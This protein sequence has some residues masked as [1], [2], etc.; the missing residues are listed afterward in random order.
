MYLRAI[1]I[2]DTENGF[3]INGIINRPKNEDSVLSQ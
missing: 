2:G 1:T 3:A